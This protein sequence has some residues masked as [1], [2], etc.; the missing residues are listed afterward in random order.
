MSTMRRQFLFLTIIRS[1]ISIAGLKYLVRV[2]KLSLTSCIESRT[3]IISYIILLPII[4]TFIWITALNVSVQDDRVY[5]KRA[6]CIKCMQMWC[7]L[8]RKIRCYMHLR[9]HK[10]LLIYVSTRAL[11]LTVLI[12]ISARLVRLYKFSIIYC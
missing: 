6:K 1:E 8:V 9:V 12:R 2:L 10:R 7:S 11:F 4:F 5:C 3:R